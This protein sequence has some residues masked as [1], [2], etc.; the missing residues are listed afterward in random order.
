MRGFDVCIV[1]VSLSIAGS[2]AVA[3]QPAPA[4]P[5]P[6]QRPAPSRPRPAPAPQAAGMTNAD[7]VKMVKAGLG[8]SV[9]V[10][11]IRQAPKR[12]FTL[13]ADA[14]V[15]L[16]SAGVSDSIIR[17]MLDPTSTA[18]AA[19]APSAPAPSA[20]TPSA[21][22]TV[23]AG[24]GASVE[25]KGPAPSRPGSTQPGI[26]LE[27]DGKV[28]MI[29]SS[30]VTKGKPGGVVKNAAT[31]G[32]KGVDIK[33]MID[34]SKSEIRTKATSPA[35]LFRGDLF[36]PNDYALV[37]VEAKEDRRELKTGKVGLFGRVK[38]EVDKNDM[39]A[40]KLSK[41]EDGLW[42]VVPEKAMTTGEYAFVV[43]TALPERV[44]SFGID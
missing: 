1:M 43:A 34:G 35:F 31:L 22:T 8:E 3:Q 4:K 20:A 25:D 23:A 30:V 5:A 17:V 13:S 10:L 37:S 15:E 21:A 12:S 14:L 38:S 42:R 9:I 28:T 41:M 16:K 33:S 29:S 7:V 6:V 39:V 18:A 2:P 36:K 27:I 19:E 11:S 44:W 24:S 26:Y 40:V 32:L